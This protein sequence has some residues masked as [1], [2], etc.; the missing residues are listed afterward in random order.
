M[1]EAREVMDRLTDAVMGGRADEVSDLY[2]EN[3][4][5][6]TPDAGEVRG[7]DAISAYFNQFSQGFPDASWEPLSKLEASN[8]AI[9]EGYFIGTHT[10]P[11]ETPTGETIPPTGKQVRLRECDV[12][13]VENGLITSHRFYFD[14]MEFVEQLGLAP[15]A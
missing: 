6:M 1:G 12:A 9:D 14:Q 3:A 11:L 8:T 10:G 15:P 2:A 5:V 13:T 7:R 4:T